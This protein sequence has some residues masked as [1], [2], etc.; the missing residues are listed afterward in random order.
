MMMLWTERTDIES[1]FTRLRQPY[2]TTRPPY[3]CLSKHLPQGDS[4]PQDYTAH[5]EDLAQQPYGTI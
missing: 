5:Q 2:G 4:T 1:F 3:W